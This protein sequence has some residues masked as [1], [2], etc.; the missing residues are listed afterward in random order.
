[1]GF[2]FG[3]GS[4]TFFFNL[5]FVCS[6]QYR[7][8]EREFLRQREAVCGFIV[9]QRRKLWDP[10]DGWFGNIE[11]WR[12]WCQY[13]TLLGGVGKY[14]INANLGFTYEMGPQ[15]QSE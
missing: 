11:G 14:A 8:E 13:H 1:M 5:L 6:N 7:G 15:L 10:V 12:L 4:L 9:P 3:L 2:L